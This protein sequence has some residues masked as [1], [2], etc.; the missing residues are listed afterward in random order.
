MLLMAGRGYFSYT[1]WK[2]NV[3]ADAQ[4]VWRMQAN[5]VL[6]VPEQQ[7]PSRSG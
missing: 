3:A 6:P 5:N 1:A 7:G 4:L 2:D